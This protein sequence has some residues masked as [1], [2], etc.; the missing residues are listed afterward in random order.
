MFCMWAFF[1]PILRRIPMLK[2]ILCFFIVLFIANSYGQK[3]DADENIFYRRSASFSRSQQ[4]ILIDAVKKPSI[5]YELRQKI[6]QTHLQM[7]SLPVLNTQIGGRE[8]SAKDLAKSFKDHHGNFMRTNKDDDIED[9]CIEY[10]GIAAN[11]LIIINL[12]A[13]RKLSNDSIS[14]PE[15]LSYFT[16]IDTFLSCKDLADYCNELAILNEWGDYSN[17]TLAVIPKGVRLQAMIGRTGEKE[18][19]NEQLEEIRKVVGVDQSI[20]YTKKRGGGVQIFIAHVSDYVVYD[21]GSISDVLFE[22]IC[23]KNRKGVF[24]E[25]PTLDFLNIS[26]KQSFSRMHAVIQSIY[27]APYYINPYPIFYF[28]I[29]SFLTSFYYGTPLEFSLNKQKELNQPVCNIALS[30]K[31]YSKTKA[32][33][34]FKCPQERFFVLYP[35]TPKF[36]FSN[37]SLRRVYI[38][39]CLMRAFKIFK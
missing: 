27:K 5:I 29:Q 1:M 15:S 39:P 38:F 17:V 3:D 8:L 24:T 19:D 32:V 34:P 36:Y 7:L 14:E 9:D 31:P 30:V 18:T 28:E 21:V 26:F 4:Q 2:Y 13:K 6:I 16:T 10:D 37:V 25:L 33:I 11:T 12:R 35:A 22:K 23:F 20:H